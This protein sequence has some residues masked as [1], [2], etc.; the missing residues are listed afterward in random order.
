MS[1]D[2]EMRSMSIRCFTIIVLENRLAE[3]YS[4]NDNY[5]LIFQ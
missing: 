2:E 1:L 5:N 3:A 4:G